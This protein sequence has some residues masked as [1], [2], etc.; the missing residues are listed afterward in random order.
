MS[1]L[2][3]SAVIGAPTLAGL[4]YIIKWGGPHFYFYAWLFTFVFTIIMLTIYPNFIAPLFNKFTPL[5]DVGFDVFN[6]FKKK[7]RVKDWN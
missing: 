6:V 5:P 3:L 4:L 2:F 7:G 1:V